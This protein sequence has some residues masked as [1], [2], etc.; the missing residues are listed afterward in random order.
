MDAQAAANEPKEAVRIE[1]PTAQAI[2]VPSINR[3]AKRSAG[4]QFALNLRNRRR[5]STV[6]SKPNMIHG[7]IVRFPMHPHDGAPATPAEALMIE[8]AKK[9]TAA[10]QRAA[11][12]ATPLMN[13]APNANSPVAIAPLETRLASQSAC[14][15]ADAARTP[16]TLRVAAAMRTMPMSRINVRG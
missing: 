12:T 15:A 4:C 9:S 5:S 14:A 13:H 6:R 7:L 8:N 16:E 3:I 2:P 1:T 11:S 10:V